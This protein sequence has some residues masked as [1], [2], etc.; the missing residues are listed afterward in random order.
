MLARLRGKDEQNEW[1]DRPMKENNIA[2]ADRRN[3]ASR[4]LV[5]LFCM[6]LTPTWPC[7]NNRTRGKDT[8]LVA[9]DRLDRVCFLGIETTSATTLPGRATW[10]STFA[11]ITQKPGLNIDYKLSKNAL[12]VHY[13]TS[14]GLTFFV[15]HLLLIIVILFYEIINILLFFLII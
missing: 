2:K 8:F 9:S 4:L 1:N 12:T 7:G 15:L 13:K 3:R 6:R 14:Y 5:S 10:A 11:F